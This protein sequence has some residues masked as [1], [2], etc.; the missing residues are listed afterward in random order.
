MTYII[1][2][3]GTIFII[4]VA[5]NAILSLSL[6]FLFGSMF[7]MFKY[8]IRAFRE[9]KRLETVSWTPVLNCVNETH[10]GS[11][12]IRAFR[13]ERE[14]ET[15]IYRLL[16]LNCLANDTQIGAWCWYGVRIGLLQVTLLLFVLSTLV[17]N[18]GQEDIVLVSMVLLYATKLQ[19][20]IL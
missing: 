18:R 11:A 10:A 17:L 14:F 7:W 8:A 16:N 12:T 1:V 6:P 2:A 13:K 20:A 3:I 9:G 5:S 19:G 4:V 15:R